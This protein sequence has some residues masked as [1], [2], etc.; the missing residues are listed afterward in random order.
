MHNGAG[1]VDARVTSTFRLLSDV[2]HYWFAPGRCG[3]CDKLKPMTPLT[4]KPVCCAPVGDRC[5]EGV[6]WHP[7]EEA[8]YWTDIT[9]FLIHRFD[10]A[11]A[12]V[13]SWFFDE[14]VTAVLLTTL[15]HVLAVCLGSRVILWEP[16][17]DARRDQGFQLPNWPLVRLNDAAVDPRGSLWVGSMRNNVNADGSDGEAGGTDGSLFRID[18]NGQVTEVEAGIGIANTLAWS[19]DQ[20][21]FYFADTLVN[22][23]WAYDYDNQT[24]SIH[25]TG[26]HLADFSR[27]LPDGSTIDADGF[28]WNC[29]WDGA[30]IVRVAPAGAVDSVI[31]MPTRNITNCT[32]GGKDL[33]TLYVTSAASPTDKGDRLAGS[34]FAVKTNLR[35][36]PE[37]R[38]HLQ[39]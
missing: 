19:P 30:C 32:F 11:T 13:K 21:I 12:A 5:G 8:V 3:V 15:N 16:A 20:E 2:E 33:D 22:T 9:R 25:K 35:G 27:G 18:P 26:N 17:T 4:G 31:E 1:D 6:L 29:R 39:D 28:V 34:L 10:P 37:N 24:G 7:A 38:F 23:I 14:P 36:L